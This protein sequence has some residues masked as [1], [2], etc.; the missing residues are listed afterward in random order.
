MSKIITL[1]IS[2]EYALKIYKL[3]TDIYEYKYL[4]DNDFNFTH[5]SNIKNNVN[6]LQ[7][8]N[9]INKIKF[10]YKITDKL[11]NKQIECNPFKFNYFSMLLNDIKLNLKPENKNQWTS[12]KF[13]KLYKPG[14]K[15]ICGGNNKYILHL[16]YD[17]KINKFF[18]DKRLTGA[19]N[20]KRSF[21]NYFKLLL[22]KY[23]Q[24]IDSFDIMIHL[25]DSRDYKFDWKSVPCFISEGNG[26]YDRDYNKVTLYTIS[27]GIVRRDFPYQK[28]KYLNSSFLSSLTNN[29]YL[30]NISKG[31][32]LNKKNIAVFRGAA[33]NIP[34]H[35]IRDKVVYYVNNKLDKEHA[36]L[37]DA[38][39]VHERKGVAIAP[40]CRKYSINNSYDKGNKKMLDNK[41]C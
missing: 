34:K 39:F 12:N 7:M 27:R 5:Y 9:E 28:A 41:K 31:E 10:V 8:R 19:P 3:S 30:M 35:K 6:I 26:D 33:L 24:Y 13:D 21:L 29:A 32:F 16:K 17:K 20:Y 1:N 11:Y 23:S 22:R 14:T 15:S 40:L 38:K 2:H 36:K 25:I 18:V 4:I 37:F